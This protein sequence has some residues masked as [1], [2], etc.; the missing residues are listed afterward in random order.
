[1]LHL[2]RATL[3]MRLFRE[4]VAQC[5]RRTAQGPLHTISEG[6]PTQH[7][8]T[9]MPQCTQEPV[10]CIHHKKKGSCK[11]VWPLTVKSFMR[12][13]TPEQCTLYISEEEAKHL[14]LK[15]TRERDTMKAVNSPAKPIAST[16]QSMHVL[17]R[18]WSK[19]L[20]FF[21]KP[22]DDFRMVLGMKFFNQVY[23]FLLQATNSFIIFE[24]SKECMVLAKRTMKRHFRPCSSRKH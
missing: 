19:K 14:G 3:G 24:M 13:W 20:D 23:A 7:R 4:E 18:M 17:I 8:F 2:Q 6:T 22:M 11:W 5:P 12:C 21:I 10:A 1:M 16:T 15:A 9:S